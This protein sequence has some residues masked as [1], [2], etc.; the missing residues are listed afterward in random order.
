MTEALSMATDVA[1]IHDRLSRMFTAAS[2]KHGNNYQAHPSDII[3]ATYPKCGTTLMQQI[4]HGLR[5]CGDMDFGEIT[6]VVP[7]LE[8]SLDVGTDIYAEQKAWPKAFKSHQT[9]EEVPKGAKYIYVLRDPKDVAVSFFHF[10]E[11]WFFARGSLTIDTFVR[12]FLLGGTRSG[13]Y[14]DHLR[15]WWH[16]RNDADTKMLCFEDITKNL[17]P[18]VAQTAEFIGIDADADCLAIASA[19]AEFAFMHAHQHQFDDHPIRLKRNVLSGLPLETQGSK[20]RAGKSGSHSILS[21]ELLERFDRIWAEEIYPITGHA[22]YA[23][24][25]SELLHV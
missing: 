2:R 14:A 25:R 8:T 19:Q 20:V 16:K 4:V 18:T 7:W 5:T 1:G 13:G 3:I 10:F 21:A 11:G 22:D 6:D 17:A 12:D 15:S 24:L 23:S 9:W